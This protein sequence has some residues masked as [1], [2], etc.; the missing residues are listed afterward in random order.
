[1]KKALIIFCVLF[2]LTL[3][4]PAAAC[5]TGGG[6]DSATRELVTIFSADNETA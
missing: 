5:F 3:A 4:V 6:T 2:V 1:M